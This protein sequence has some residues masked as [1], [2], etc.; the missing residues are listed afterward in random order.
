[1]SKTDP[2]AHALH[3]IELFAKVD[4]Q[5]VPVTAVIRKPFECVD[6]QWLCAANISGLF[7][8]KADMERATSIESINAARKFVIEELSTYV[9]DGGQ[10]FTV[11]H[12]PVTDLRSVISKKPLQSV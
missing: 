2:L 12:K 3:K 6:T 4:G 11:N 8:R 7:H 5:H 1:M 10:L 9:A